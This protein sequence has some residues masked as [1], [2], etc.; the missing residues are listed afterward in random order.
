MPLAPESN[1]EELSGVTLIGSASITYTRAM[2][3]AVYRKSIE[4]IYTL[5]LTKKGTA[6]SADRARLKTL[7]PRETHLAFVKERYQ[8]VRANVLL[9]RLDTRARGRMQIA[10][11]LPIL[12]LKGR[13]EAP[14]VTFPAPDADNA[15]QR[16]RE[17][18]LQDERFLQTLPVY[19]YA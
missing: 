11:E 13:Y 18:K 16:E 14:V 7:S 6:A 12:Y 10:A 4:E 8:N 9:H 19:R 2:T 17:S 5:L 15:P 3:R 1:A